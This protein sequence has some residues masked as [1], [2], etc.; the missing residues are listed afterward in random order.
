[1]TQHLRRIL[2]PTHL[3]AHRLRQIEQLDQHR[4]VRLRDLQPTA[5]DRL[6]E[7][8]SG[9]AHVL[10]LTPCGAELR[11][12]I[13]GYIEETAATA[14][15]RIECLRPVGIAPFAPLRIEGVPARIWLALNATVS[16]GSR[17]VIPSPASSF[18]SR[19]TWRGEMPNAAAKS[20]ALSPAAKRRATSM[21]SSSFRFFA[22]LGTNAFSRCQE[23]N[24]CADAREAA[25]ARNRVRVRRSIQ[26][27]G[28][29]P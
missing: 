29:R 26:L 23:K 13:T 20:F 11:D 9:V 14:Q 16:L 8:Q 24:A 18:A 21:R 7:H 1:M 15:H 22:G 2:H 25:I 28:K 10:R 19:F 4:P 6:G 12:Q 5:M 17:T 3:T 27:C